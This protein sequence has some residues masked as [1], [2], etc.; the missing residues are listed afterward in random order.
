M[1]TAAFLLFLA[2]S[3]YGAAP[4]VATTWSRS[5]LLSINPTDAR[6]K[7]E[8]GGD[9]IN[10]T[11]FGAK[12][13]GVTDDTGAFEDALATTPPWTLMIPP[14]RYNLTNWS[15]KLIG[16]ANFVGEKG[17]SYLL[18]NSNLNFISLTGNVNVSGICFS[19]WLHPIYNTSAVDH[20]E[21]KDSCFERCKTAF[22][23]QTNAWTG[24]STA[25]IRWFEFDNNRYDG[26]YGGGSGGFAGVYLRA[27]YGSNGAAVIT[28]NHMV[29]LNTSAFKFGDNVE[30]LMDTWQNTTISHNSI[31]P[32]TNSFDNYGV[33]LYGKNASITLNKIHDMLY[34]ATQ[35]ASGVYVKCRR[36]T[37]SENHLINCGGIQG[38]ITVKGVGRHEIGTGVGGY[39]GII[40]LNQ[41]EA[42]DH[43]QAVGIYID[44]DD[45]LAE[46][47]MIDG[48]SGQPSRRVSG[49]Y[50][51]D[52]QR[53]SLIGNEVY[54]SICHRVVDVQASS[55]I[56]IEN[57][58]IDGVFGEAGVANEI[59]GFSAGGRMTNITVRGN[60]IARST[61]LFGTEIGMRFASAVTNLVIT[62]NT[63]PSDIPIAFYN[64]FGSPLENLLI[65]GNIFQRSATSY[66]QPVYFA[67]GATPVHAEIY[68]NI[69]FQP[70]TTYGIFA[71]GDRNPSVSYMDGWF[72]CINT[73]ST[74]ITN[75]SNG[76]NGQILPIYFTTG[77][78]TIQHLNTAIKMKSGANTTVASGSWMTFICRGG[79]WWEIEK[80]SQA[81]NTIELAAD[82]IGTPL[83]VGTSNT[84]GIFKVDHNGHL[85]VG[86]GSPQVPMQIL[87][88]NTMW[89]SYGVHLGIFDTPPVNA[90]ANSGGSIVFG[91]TFDGTLSPTHWGG[92]SGYK[93]DSVTNNFGGGLKL[94]TRPNGGA[95]T[96]RFKIGPDGS[97]SLEKTITGAGT[98]AVQTINK[99]SG[100][101]NVGAGTN[102]ITLNNSQVTT[103]SIVYPCVVG[104]DATA[105]TVGYSLS[106]GVVTFYLNAPAT[107]EV[108][109]SWLVT[110]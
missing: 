9:V 81:N 14:G 30:T 65:H 47:N 24:S 91:G 110:N 92:I 52:C 76:H 98:V 56:T 87:S 39:S 93:E 97:I 25:F 108:G 17:Q 31:G 11:W 19:N 94:W 106:A 6:N 44:E 109:I 38:A 102:T 21:I 58:L 80:S 100:R 28:R 71:D 107:A 37:I 8:L 26:Q 45:V 48:F 27:D 66:I 99:A 86:T 105:K 43:R 10:V 95:E 72:E 35:E 90:I 51:G 85:I 84:I 54:N 82:A 103:S 53:V 104:N 41:I 96:E 23:H 18:G 50:I 7:L 75:F 89:S 77:N 78:T 13:D 1:R 83:I 4:I 34:S 69:G 5:F 49:F 46:S 88:S 32:S 68:G 59:I 29:N 79:V 63:I 22:Y 60:S 67:P 12:G 2:T 55:D 62:G 57:T 70:Y 42:P 74:A 64:S 73:S 20:V 61:N 33:L 36:Y 40:S 101:I 16:N 15:Q 3:A